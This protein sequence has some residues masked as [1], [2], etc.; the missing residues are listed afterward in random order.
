MFSRKPQ[1]KMTKSADSNNVK[2]NPS[3]LDS[4]ILSHLTVLFK[5]VYNDLSQFTT[6]NDFKY[7]HSKFNLVLF[8]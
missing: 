1:I 4:H 2:Q 7:Q 5:L 6:K 3:M 8:F